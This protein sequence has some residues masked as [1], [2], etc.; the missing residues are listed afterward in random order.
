MQNKIEIKYVGDSDSWEMTVWTD[1]VG[2]Q[3]VQLSTDQAMVVALAIGIAKKV[4]KEEG[5]DKAKEKYV[6]IKNLSNYNMP[7][8]DAEYPMTWNMKLNDPNA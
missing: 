4:G 8:Q 3:V 5:Y 6:A 2:K 1:I 7:W